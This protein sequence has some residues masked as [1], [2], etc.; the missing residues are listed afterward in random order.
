[1]QYIMY[2][3]SVLNICKEILKKTGIR[4][5]KNLKKYLRNSI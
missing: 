1:V 4:E 5:K 3:K 2:M